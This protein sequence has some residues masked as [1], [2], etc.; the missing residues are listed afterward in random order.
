[1]Q[2]NTT[3]FLNGRNARIF[4]EELWT[5]LVNAMENPAGIPEAFI[6]QKK[7]EMKKRD[8]ETERV[9]EAVRQAERDMM[10]REMLKDAPPRGGGGSG[11]GGGFGGNRA[12]ED[13]TRRRRRFRSR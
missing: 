6:E 4:M 9:K 7:L 2:I 11:G 5:H 3:G 13:D 10:R 1:M 8:E 12:V